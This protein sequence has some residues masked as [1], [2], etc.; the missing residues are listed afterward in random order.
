MVRSITNMSR[1]GLKDWMVQRVS[2]VLLGTYAA[3]MF[4]YLMVDGGLTYEQWTSLFGNI[5]FKIYTLAVLFAL[6]AHIWVGMWTVAT[7]YLK[8]AW[9]RFLVLGFIALVNFVYFVIGF[10]AVWSV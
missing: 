8:N 10:S 6:V 7:D 9:V 5:V 1:S 2:A 4:G 3:F